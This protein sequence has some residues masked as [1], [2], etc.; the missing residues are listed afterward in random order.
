MTAIDALAEPSSERIRLDI[1]P[2]EPG[3]EGFVIKSWRGSWK[4]SP[5][6]RSLST[7]NF[8]SV[9]DS[10]VRNGVLKQP[11]TRV[12]VGADESDPGWIWCWLCYTPGLVPTLHYAITR[13]FRIADI[14]SDVYDRLRFMA[15][16]D[17]YLSVRERGMFRAL[18]AAAGVCRELVYTFRPTSAEVER[19][20]LAAAKEAGITV[21]YRGVEEFLQHRRAR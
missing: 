20:L 19:G 6:C 1:R 2:M 11:D 7:R 9:F 14:P 5:R 21:S 8:G 13:Q 17:G 3:D 10:V 16:P 18:V 12:L 15:T 4:A